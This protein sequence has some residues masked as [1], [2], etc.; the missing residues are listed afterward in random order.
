MKL[1]ESVKPLG[2]LMLAIPFA[3]MIAMIGTNHVNV[4]AYQEY[5]LEIMGYDPR[6]LLRGHYI[7]FRYVWPEVAIDKFK[8]DASLRTAQTCACLSG[9]AL[10]PDVRFDSCVSMHEQPASCPDAIPVS[11]S[12]DDAQPDN[13]LLQ[14]YIPQEHAALLENMLRS[15]KYKFSVGV[16]PR[17]G[18]L[19]QLR[20]LYVDGV[21]L[22]EILAGD[23]TPYL[24]TP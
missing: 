15:G 18:G 8:A 4:T 11:P 9:D 17:P 20:M 14:Y 16:V 22:D 2:L 23:L 5:R 10:T 21:S 7:T 19:A 12:R 3:A 24:A 13:S 1:A 6:D